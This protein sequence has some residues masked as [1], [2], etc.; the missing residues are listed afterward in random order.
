MHCRRG[1]HFLAWSLE[2]IHYTPEQ[3]ASL[4]KHSGNRIWHHGYRVTLSGTN[5]CNEKG[6][7]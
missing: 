2:K 6:A 7:V 4:L 1:L 3:A 5:Y